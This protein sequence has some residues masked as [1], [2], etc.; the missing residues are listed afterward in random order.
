MRY[1]LNIL[2]VDDTKKLYETTKDILMMY[3]EDEGLS[4]HFE[5]IQDVDIFFERLKSNERGF[6]LYDIF[7]VD[8]S[9]SDKAN[10]DALISELRK[11]EFY[12]DILFYTAYEGKEIKQAVGDEELFH[13]GVY[14]ANKD[15]IDDKGKL[16]IKKNAKGMTSL[17]NIRGYLMDQTSE[18]DFT[19]KSYILEKYDALGDEKKTEITKMVL[20]SIKHNKDKFDGDADKLIQG[21]EKTGIQ[22]INRLI[23]TQDALIPIRLKYGIFA[24]M[25]E[26]DKDKSFG[27]VNVEDYFEEIVGNRN[28]LAHKKLDVCKTQ[29][30][31][32]YYDTL[33]QMKDR[34]CPED[35]SEHSDD[36]KISIGQWGDLRKKIH[37]FGESMDK[38]QQSLE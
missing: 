26:E 3:A 12:A 33:S 24:K 22:N 32:L 2:W 35:C 29:E 5:Y 17:A 9:L 14:F 37:K 21:L 11:R 8:Y 6:Q 16:L 19:V 13:D 28:K 4:V 25:L 7:F 15:A 38:I 34:K 31:I 27:E 30:Y 36:F 20:D 23:Q 1:D 10:G 18:N